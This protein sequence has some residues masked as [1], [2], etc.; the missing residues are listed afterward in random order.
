MKMVR[1]FWLKIYPILSA[2]SCLVALFSLVAMLGWRS[3]ASNLIDLQ[4]KGHNLGVAN[5]RDI[6]TLER[7]VQILE[8]ERNVMV[9]ELARLQLQQD[10]MMSAARSRGDW[11]VAHAEIAEWRRLLST[12]GGKSGEWISDLVRG[13]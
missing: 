13:R 10:M 4:L 9:V 6:R 1:E 3:V 5:V 2:V 8:G 7:Q 12:D 11:I